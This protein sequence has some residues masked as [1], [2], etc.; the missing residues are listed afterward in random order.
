MELEHPVILSQSEDYNYSN[1]NIFECNKNR[2]TFHMDIPSRPQNC[3][4]HVL[5][6]RVEDQN[7]T[8]SVSSAI[9]WPMHVVKESVLLLESIFSTRMRYDILITTNDFHP[10]LGSW[11]WGVAE[12]VLSFSGIQ[13]FPPTMSWEM[14]FFNI[15]TSTMTNW[16]QEKETDYFIK[17][18]GILCHHCHPQ[19]YPHQ[20][21]LIHSEKDT[22][23]TKQKLSKIIF[24]LNANTDKI[25]WVLYNHFSPRKL[26]GKF[27]DPKNKRK[28]LFFQHATSLHKLNDERLLFYVLGNSSFCAPDEDSERYELCN[29]MFIPFY[30]H[31]SYVKRHPYMRTQFP[32]HYRNLQ[33][34]SCGHLTGSLPYLEILSPYKVFAWVAICSSLMILPIVLTGM[35][36]GSSTIQINGYQWKSFK[37]N[38]ETI[39]KYENWKWRT[40]YF[41]YFLGT[42]KPLVDQGPDEI[43]EAFSF[44]PLRISITIYLLMVIILSNGYKGENITKLVSP[45]PPVPFTHFEELVSQNY[46]IVSKLLRVSDSSNISMAKLTKKF[47]PDFLEK[48]SFNIKGVHQFDLVHYDNFSEQAYSLSMATELSAQLLGE[49][50]MLNLSRR[51][52]Y[53]LNNTRMNLRRPIKNKKRG[54]SWSR[55]SGLVL[56]QNCS[57]VTKFAVVA[58]KTNIQKFHAMYTVN[59]HM[60]NY[61]HATGFQFP[62]SFGKDVLTSTTKGITMLN[63]VNPKIV[64][65]FK[66]LYTSGIIDWHESLNE[67]VYRDSGRLVDIVETNH[68]KPPTLTTSFKLLF[69]IWMTGAIVGCIVFVTE[70]VVHSRARCVSRFRGLLKQTF[71]YFHQNLLARTGF[72]TDD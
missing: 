69:F 45:I 10:N 46:D 42:L 2:S 54:T 33:W 55:H 60:N 35:E 28:G 52:E 11:V 57:K 21:I 5:I 43:S 31:L 70:P 51:E 25:T 37:Q 29:S 50:S 30:P 26:F 65:R 36:R 48:Q 18:V 34:V 40:T 71:S 56:L 6:L 49:S 14:L 32:F 13:P 41:N 1:S 61:D 63:W 9:Q 59:K 58:D 12:K 72:A 19:H 3:E 20:P 24:E 23:L 44:A 17:S 47:G 15:E 38:I 68:F 39:R 22:P 62:L 67:T 64:L 27:Q 8:L 16:G 53:I 7:E 66:G 4:A